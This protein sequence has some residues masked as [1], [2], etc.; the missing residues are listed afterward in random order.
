MSPKI[1]SELLRNFRKYSA[2][3]VQHWRPFSVP[4]CGEV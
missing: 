3:E 1:N 2:F 4:E